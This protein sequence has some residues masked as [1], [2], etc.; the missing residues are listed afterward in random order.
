MKRI[1]DK[2]YRKTLCRNCNKYT[3]IYQYIQYNIH[4]PTPPTSSLPK[5]PTTST[6]DQQQ[7]KIHSG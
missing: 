1:K 6:V 3:K 7:T 5:P 2:T 4:M